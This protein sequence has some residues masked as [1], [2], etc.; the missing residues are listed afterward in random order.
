MMSVSATQK[1]KKIVINPVTRIEGH[2]KVTIRLD[3]NGNVDTARMHIVEFRG[4]ERFV[5]G[6]LYW[7]APVIVQR[8]C[9]ICPISRPG[10]R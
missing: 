10:R 9:G 8:L 5:Q 7:E 1:E 3:K 4:F 6:R 2:A